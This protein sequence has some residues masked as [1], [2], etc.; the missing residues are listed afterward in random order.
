MKTTSS[1]DSILNSGIIVTDGLRVYWPQ[2]KE[3]ESLKFNHRRINT[4]CSNNGVII[5]TNGDGI[6]HVAV[7]SHKLMDAIEEA[8]YSYENQYVPFSNWDYPVDQKEV[9]FQMWED[10]KKEREEEFKEDCEKYSDEH[11]FGSLPNEFLARCFAIPRNGLEV[12][13]LWGAKDRIEP[14]IRASSFDCTVTGQLGR[15][16]YN[17]GRSLCCGRDGTQYVIRGYH[18][19]ELKRAGYT[20]RG[21]FVPFSN[22]EVPANESLRREW[23]RLVS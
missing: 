16:Y 4:Y 15:F 10:I 22:G 14:A 21:L 18:V 7:A 5:W 9:W 1:L 17:N 13:Y 6:R 23:E 3:V 20:V 11:G 2:C 19:E 12:Q 8:G